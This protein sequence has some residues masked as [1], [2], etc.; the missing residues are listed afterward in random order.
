MP[1]AKVS[2]FTYTDLTKI[3]SSCDEDIPQFTAVMLEF[4]DSTSNV[5]KVT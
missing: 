5:D 2:S 4:E 3:I 1:C